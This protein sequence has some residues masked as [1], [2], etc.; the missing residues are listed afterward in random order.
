MDETLILYF[1]GYCWKL[2][3]YPKWSL[4]SH[5]CNGYGYWI[6]GYMAVQIESRVVSSV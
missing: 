4:F 2:N 3:F 1:F 6:H 5:I